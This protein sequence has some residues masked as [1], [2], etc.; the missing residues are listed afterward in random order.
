MHV[1]VSTDRNIQAHEKM[2][3]WISSTV[4]DA[5]SNFGDNVTRVDV[6]LS[7]TNSNKKDSEDDIR[8][9]LEARFKGRKPI[10]VTH[11]AG[12][13]DPALMGAATKLTRVLNSR[14]GR[15]QNQHRR[16]H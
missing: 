15:L 4:S 8:C 14:L 10:A 16:I 3:S 13:L 2:M 7:D 11:R 5:L 1:Q 6:H 12:D 9:V